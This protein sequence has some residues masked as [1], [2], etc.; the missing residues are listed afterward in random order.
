MMKSYKRNQFLVNSQPERDFGLILRI[1]FLDKLN[2]VDMLEFCVKF[3]FVNPLEL[4]IN[5]IETQY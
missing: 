4:G 3:N 5:L 1:N 2:N